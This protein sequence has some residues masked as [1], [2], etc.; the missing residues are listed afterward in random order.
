VLPI[1]LFLYLAAARPLLAP[2][3]PDT[4]ELLTEGVNA[5]LVPPGD[6]NATVSA[7][8]T[9][10][11]E[12]AR[13]ERL[14][15]GAHATAA[16]LTWDARAGHILDFLAT[17]LTAPPDSLPSGQWSSAGWLRECAGWALGRRQLPGGPA[18]PPN[19]RTA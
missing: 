15:A 16:D 17:R 1:K 19:R 10:V 5:L 3:A 13:A 4:A 7:L 9:L 2:R 14:A 12:P 8:R 18:E 6:V 11:A